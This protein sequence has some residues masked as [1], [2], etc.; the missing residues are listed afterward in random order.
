MRGAF[1]GVLLAIWNP[2]C[3]V[4]FQGPVLSQTPTYF[5]SLGF[6]AYMVYVSWLSVTLE[7]EPEVLRPQVSAQ[8][9]PWW[10]HSWKQLCSVGPAGFL[11]LGL[12]R[13]DTA[14]KQFMLCGTTRRNSYKSTEI[15][16]NR[17]RSA[18]ER[19]TMVCQRSW[20]AIAL[21]KPP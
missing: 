7:S 1:L 8:L 19:S 18:T 15:E 9:R 14:A 3:R 2:L 16:T 10:S 13:R 5:V 12:H 17:S 21:A 11:K 4:L 6:R 20:H